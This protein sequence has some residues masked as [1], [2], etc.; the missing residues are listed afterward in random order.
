MNDVSLAQARTQAGQQNADLRAELNR[1][2]SD[3]TNLR[4]QLAEREQRLQN[5]NEQLA[6]AQTTRPGIS[7]DNSALRAQLI[8]L[9]GRVQTA[10]DGESQADLRAE[11]V[12]GELA[13]ANQKIASLEQSLLQSQSLQRGV[14]SRLPS[15]MG[16]TSP[17]TPVQIAEL[18]SLR[19]Q[20]KRLQEQF[21]TLANA[22]GRQDLDRRIQDLN[23]KT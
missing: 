3:V 18:N 11:R 5:L 1:S 21:Q 17:L 2:L 13:A 12:R 9:Q 8:R 6:I 15:T 14:P 10:L 7:P 22:P 23:Q 20:N 19:E 16:Q 4:N